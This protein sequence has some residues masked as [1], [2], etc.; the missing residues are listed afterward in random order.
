MKKDKKWQDL[1]ILSENRLA[2]RTEFRTYRN[3]AELAAERSSLVQSL[4]GE[5]NFLFL[6]APEYSPADFWQ[7]DFDDSAWDRLTVPST[8]QTKGYGKMHYTDVHYLF[9]IC[10]PYVPNDNPTG[11]YRRI[12]TVSEERQQQRCI[13]KFHGVDSAFEI[14]VNGNYVGYSQG[15]RY[16]SE[17]NVSSVI[18]AGEN[19][20]TVRV[21]QWSDGSYLEDQDMWWL[22]GIF[23]EVELL[24]YP[25]YV[26][27][28][29]VC[30]DYIPES[31]KGILSIQGFQP[32]T[33]RMPG[34]D[35]I[36]AISDQNGNMLVEEKIDI[37]AEPEKEPDLLF[38]WQV[39]LTEVKAWTAE[40]P[41]LYQW[42][43]VL[44]QN[45]Q[46]LQVLSEKFGFRRIAVSGCRLLLNGQPIQFHGVNYHDYDPHNG[47]VLTEEI[48]RADLKLMK[49]HNI[50]AIRCAHYPK[51]DIFYRLC[52]EYGFYVID[53]ADLECHG[54]ELTGDYNWLPDDPAWEKAFVERG[55]RMVMAH[56]NHP[57]ILMWS[58]GN[59]SGF[60]NNFKVMA[61][62]IRQVDRSRLIHYEGDM[63][64]EIADVY[65][66]MYTRYDKLI[67][68]GLNYSEK[69]HILCEYA[70]AM[71]NGPGGL[72]EYE[73]AFQQFEVLHGGFVWEWYDHGIAC[74][75]KGYRYGGEFG[76]SPNNGNFCIDGL[77]K[78]NREVSSGLREYKAVIQPVKCRARD[79]TK[80]LITIQNS[81]DFLD[82]SHLYLSWEITDGQK[83]LAEGQIRELDCPAGMETTLQLNY[84]WSEICQQAQANTEYYLNLEWRQK[85][86]Q[87]LIGQ[88]HSIGRQQIK[89]P[90]YR[91][92]TEVRS[93]LENQ[94]VITEDGTYLRVTAGERSYTF[95]TLHG[96]LSEITEKGKRI[97]KAGPQLTVDRAVIDNDMYKK[98]DYY[99]KFFL[100][101]SFEDCRDLSWEKLG[102]QV[103]VTIDNYFSCLNQSFGFAL[104]YEY[105]I[106][107]DGALSLNLKAKYQARGSQVPELLPRL[108]LEMLLSPEYSE[109][110]WQGKGFFENY[111]DSA[112]SSIYGVYQA[113]V[114][115]M[116]EF[117]VYPQENGHRE[118]VRW[119]ALA[120]KENS[121]LVRMAE[122]M[123]INVS[124]YGTKALAKAKH[125]NELEKT[126]GIWLTV[127]Y[128][129]LG[130]GSNSCGEEQLVPYRLKPQDFEMQL[131][132]RIIPKGEEIVEG[133]KEY[134]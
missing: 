58:L 37:T 114:E 28:V 74:A 48:M 11:I 133:R 1:T 10:P 34:F 56:R 50:N 57:S 59:E 25:N 123:G 13:L 93:S 120:G 42:T 96:R 117:Y 118:G 119:L 51:T 92:K 73:R 3:R 111:P 107:Q 2:A 129:H 89:L 40:T 32:I 134:A 49:E 72:L 54:F 21:M 26:E 82:L 39:E 108:G 63:E 36:I 18:T 69:P 60:G 106:L 29:V 131:E 122:E 102:D 22:S 98:A 4:N 77:L 103:R 109:V 79:L 35:W 64:A 125:W 100:H 52:D 68:I 127:D 88:D 85:E 95:D 6:A 80:A 81:Y 55:L 130:L 91:K 70:H 7:K 90:Y 112:Q 14:W 61:T 30:S 115:E 38:S 124:Y 97:V 27:S 104:K 19:Q 8:W 16:I 132:L 12:F 65:S 44:Q 17:F 83:A 110:T 5:W 76:D 24:Y 33:E 121:L 101:Q 67:Q 45:G 9:P 86:S 47:R 105:L 15:A 113:A 78:P 128:R 46:E 75:E 87:G 116:D 62:A 41:N 84:E 66:T 71:G 94:P 31:G 126:D 53:E 23:R 20:I 43:L 99:E